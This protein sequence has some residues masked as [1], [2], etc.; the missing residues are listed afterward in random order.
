MSRS[1]LDLRL[2]SRLAD[3]ETSKQRPVTDDTAFL[4]PLQQTAQK[5]QAFES[6]GESAPTH[7]RHAR[8]GWRILE[9]TSVERRTCIM[10]SSASKDTEKPVLDR[11]SFIGLTAFA[12][13]VLSA[14]RAPGVNAQ[15][16]GARSSGA[17]VQTSAGQ[18]RGFR[19]NGVLGFRGVPYGASTAGDRRFRR[20]LPPEPWRGTRAALEPG[21]RSPQYQNAVVH[22]F[23]VMNPTEPSG[24]DCLCLNLWTPSVMDAARRPVMVWLHGGGFSAASGSWAC[25]DGA[26]LSENQDVVVVAINHRLNLFGY[27]H[28]AQL[29]IPRFEETSNL[30]MHDIILALQWIRDNIGNFGG[31]PDNVT[32]FGQS[33][34]AAKVSTLLGMP[35]AKGLFHKVIIQSGSQVRSLTP[36]RARDVAESFLYAVNLSPRTA[37]RILDIPYY[38]LRNAIPRGDFSF[39][40]VVDGITLP[41]HVFD[42]AASDISAGVPMLIGSTETEVTWNTAM[43]YD[44]LEGPALRDHTQHV[45]RC[46]A[47]TAERVI[48]TYRHGRPDATGLDLYLIIASD[49]GNARV[50]TDTQAERWAAVGPVY[51]YY[52]EWYSPVRGGVLRA[53]HCMDIPFV[54]DNLEIARVVIGD[55]AAA[56]P[57]ANQMSAAWAA[58]ARTGDPN[59]AGL[60][61]WP[62]FDTR[63]RSTMVFNIESRML[64]NPYGSEKAALAGAAENTS[65]R[66]L[67]TSPY[68][69]PIRG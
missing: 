40:P 29:G 18:V 35:D 69:S 21:P 65:A 42:P 56:Q 9:G 17:T 16:R 66:R 10:T 62:P 8:S 22:E 1:L 24:E 3:R 58:F 34:G 39:S 60:P 14:A 5:K 25:Y 13:G 36:G 44:P 38:E 63:D 19:A 32:L 46:D 49:A 2:E 52:F 59:H 68:P 53:M 61:T 30:G 64:R 54:F 28:L 37:E 31:D 33:G 43:Q 27:L 23:G 51:K 4:G 48:S 67:D 50:G 26:N 45:L 15:S 57:L 20:P 12:A 11:R 6:D 41:D 55:P 7:G 47:P